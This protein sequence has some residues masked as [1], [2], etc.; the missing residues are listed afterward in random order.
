MENPVEKVTVFLFHEGTRV[1]ILVK[2]L[3][4]IVFRDYHAYLIKLNF[5]VQMVTRRILQGPICC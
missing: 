1:K 4:R 2:N 3:V 5:G